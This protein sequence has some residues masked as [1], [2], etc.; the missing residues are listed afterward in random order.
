MKRLLLAV[1]AVAGPAMAA[2]PPASVLG[3]TLVQNKGGD[4]LGVPMQI[5]LLLTLL[6]ILPAILMSITPFLRITVVLHFLRQA[7]GTQSTPSNQVL[8]GLALVSLSDC[9]ATR[10]YAGLPAKLAAA[11]SGQYHPDGSL[12]PRVGSDQNVSV[13]LCARKRHSAFYGAFARTC[14]GHSG[15]RPGHRADA[16]VCAQ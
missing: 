8:V 4:S 3:I 9:G 2:P 12:G 15:R 14:S 6:S 11:R 7:L 16:R 1:A 13:A 5:V 10:G